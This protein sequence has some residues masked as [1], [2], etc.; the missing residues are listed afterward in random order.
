M[1]LYLLHFVQFLDS[2]SPISV[3][4]KADQ[5]QAK[6]AFQP[7]EINHMIIR[8]DILFRTATC[9]CVSSILLRLEDNLARSRCRF[10]TSSSKLLLNSLQN[11]SCWFEK[12]MIFCSILVNSVA[13]NCWNS[14]L[15]VLICEL[16][17][18]RWIQIE[19]G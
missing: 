18:E 9:N 19:M 10:S 2:L 1:I 15:S 4:H 17:L 7:S 5:W 12:S 6:T 3:Q 14:L 16:D 8:L 11:I 13:R